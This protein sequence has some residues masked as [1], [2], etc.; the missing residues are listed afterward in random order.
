MLFGVSADSQIYS[1]QSFRELREILARD[2][3]FFIS[4]VGFK[5]SVLGDP[6]DISGNGD[7]TNDK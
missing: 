5:S 4:I 3:D 7:I 2:K 1:G 6:I